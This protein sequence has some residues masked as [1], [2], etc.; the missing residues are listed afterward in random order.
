MW[1]SGVLIPWATTE[2]IRFS[3]YFLQSGNIAPPKAL[4][5][6]RYSWFIVIYPLGVSMEWMCVW[7]AWPVISACCPRVFSVE[8]PNAWNFAF[9]YQWFL[10]Y[11]VSVSYVLVFPMLYSHLW[12]QRQNK[13]KTH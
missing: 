1:I 2:I 12:R 9:D 7:D 3:L 5:Y 4:Q 10:K 8:M 11:I 6:L 13:L